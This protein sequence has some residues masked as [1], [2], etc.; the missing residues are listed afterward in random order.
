M[1]AVRSVRGI[2]HFGLPVRAML[3]R[4]ATTQR[5]GTG[6]MGATPEQIRETENRNLHATL[7]ICS[8]LLYRVRSE[9]GAGCKSRLAL[10]AA[11]PPDNLKKTKQ[12]YRCARPGVARSGT[13]FA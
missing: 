9:P 3:F 8:A 5:F 7:G 4:K 6:T 12:R 11:N 1:N 13:D 10:P 2:M